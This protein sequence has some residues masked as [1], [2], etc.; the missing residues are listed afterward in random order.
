MDRIYPFTY[1][2]KELLVIDYAGLD[3][4]G[5]RALMKQAVRT[6][7]ARP[8]NSVLALTIVKGTRFAVGTSDDVKAYLKASA[9]VGLSP[10]QRV[11]FLGLRPFL[12]TGIEPFSTELEARE[13]LVSRP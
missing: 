4:D 11:I 10:L 12:K 3:P 2:E 1:R 6:I 13:W 7:T 5:Y 8:P 9:V